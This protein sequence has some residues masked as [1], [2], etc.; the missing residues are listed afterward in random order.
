MVLLRRAEHLLRQVLA[1]VERQL[2]RTATPEL[3]GDA[4]TEPLTGTTSPTTMGDEP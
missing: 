3:V 1:A 4:I 2:E